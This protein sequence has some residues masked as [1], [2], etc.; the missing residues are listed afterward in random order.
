MLPFLFQISPILFNKGEVSKFRFTWY[1]FINRFCKPYGFQK[2]KKVIVF[3]VIP[4]PRQLLP[5]IT[6][7]RFK[8]NNRSRLFLTALLSVCNIFQIRF[9]RLGN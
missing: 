4:N 7:L 1:L 6:K 3:I 8:A 5:D 9:S 2:I